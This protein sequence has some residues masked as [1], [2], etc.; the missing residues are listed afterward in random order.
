MIMREVDNRIYD[1]LSATWWDEDGFMALLRT[2]VNP[3]RSAYFA[4]V[5]AERLQL[6]PHGLKL[7]DVGCGGGLLAEEF[8]RLGFAVTGIDQSGPSLAAARD[9]AQR[10]GLDIRYLEASANALPF[11]A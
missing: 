5:L 10:G 11:D 6:A 4:R 1:R 8:A 3:G 2:S 9:H 7:L